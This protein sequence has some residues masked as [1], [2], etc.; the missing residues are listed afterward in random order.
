MERRLSGDLRERA[1]RQFL[2]DLLGF[3]VAN[4]H[5]RGDLVRGAAAD[6]IVRRVL[7]HA[8]PRLVEELPR[9]GPAVQRLEWLGI[10]LEPPFRPAAR[11]LEVDAG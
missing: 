11:G 9:P 1:L 4:E 7:E 3:C 8:S 6:R 2:A 5:L 10:A